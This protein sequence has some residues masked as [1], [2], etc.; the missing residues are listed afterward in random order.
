MTPGHDKWIRAYLNHLLV[1]KNY[2]RHTVQAYQTDLTQLRTFLDDHVPAFA[3]EGWPAI[4]ESHLE[5][6]LGHLHDQA[7]ANTSIARKLTTI[8]TFFQHLVAENLISHDPSTILESP[9]VERPLPRAITPEEIQRLLEA[10]AQTKA[11]KGLRDQAI[12]E[13]LYAT[14]MRVSE[15]ANLR[16]HDVD[17]E[18]NVV[19]CRG[20]GNKERYIPFH[21][22]AARRLLTYLEEARPA[23]SRSETRTNALFL[24]YRGRPLTRQ[25]LWLIIRHYARVAGITA[26][27][28]PHTLRHSVATH[29][30][31]RGADLRE[32]Q[33]LLGH[34]S[35]TS[36]QWYTRVVNEH[37]RDAYDAAHPRA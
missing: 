29:M 10:P 9:K 22:T 31:R 11:P 37:L 18:R 34:T 5:A 16:L 17:L 6:Y 25:G 27:V 36:T 24:N 19:H 15:L 13:L 21:E 30:L 2:S 12:L 28:T 14:G 1:Q 32:V 20:K 3:E 7:Y 35:M 33:E 26:S 23:L 4:D 8:R